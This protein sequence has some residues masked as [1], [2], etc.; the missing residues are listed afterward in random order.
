MREKVELVKID[1]QKLTEFSKL[2]IKARFSPDGLS[3]EEDKRFNEII[4]DAKPSEDD[5]E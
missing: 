4:Q 1:P 2:L 5:A 3:F